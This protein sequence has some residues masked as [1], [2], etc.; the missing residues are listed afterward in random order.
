MGIPKMSVD[1]KAHRLADRIEVV[2]WT[3]GAGAV[4]AVPSLTTDDFYIVTDLTQLGIGQGLRCD[5]LAGAHNQACAHRTAVVL[6]R[7]GEAEQ[8]ERREGQ[9]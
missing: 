9:R 6:R 2:A 3:G 7:Q 4:Y 1:A 5:C 8:I